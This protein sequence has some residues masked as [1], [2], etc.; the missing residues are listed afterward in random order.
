MKYATKIL[1]AFK[2]FLNSKQQTVRKE[3]TGEIPLS[4]EIFLSGFLFLFILVLNLVMATFGYKMEK[5]DYNP[6]TDLNKINNN[7]KKFKTGITL[8]LIEHGSVITLTILLFIAFSSYNIILGILLL[9]FR[10]AEGL[11]QFIN[12]PNYWKLLNIAKQYSSSNEK[13]YLVKLARNIFKIKDVRFKFAMVCW[14]IGT[15][16]FS[17]TLVIV[18]VLPVAIGWLGIIA[19]ILVG[20]TTMIKL[21]NPSSRDLTAIGGLSAI[22]FEVTIGIALLYYAII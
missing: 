22:L 17:I 7:P 20:S 2:A 1:T 15:L 21:V 18:D 16:A 9:I 19:S 3:L 6:E 10:T 8:A 4:V 14:S 12:E 11:I 5:E 13:D